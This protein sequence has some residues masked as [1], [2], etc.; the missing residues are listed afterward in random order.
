MKRW[1]TPRFEEVRLPVAPERRE[2][3]ARTEDFQHGSSEGHPRSSEN[4]E[5]RSGVTSAPRD[6]A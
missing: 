4:A 1:H 5:T 3:W 6:G 2:A